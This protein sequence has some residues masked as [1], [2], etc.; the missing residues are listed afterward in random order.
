MTKV[1]ASKEELSE[2][3]PQGYKTFFMLNSV[4]NEISTAYKNFM[5]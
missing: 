5:L 3:W 2:I 4:E 1:V